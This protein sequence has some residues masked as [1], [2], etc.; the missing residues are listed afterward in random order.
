MMEGASEEHALSDESLGSGATPGPVWNKDHFDHINLK[1][2]LETDGEVE[3]LVQTL[4]HDKNEFKSRFRV[5]RDILVL[6][7]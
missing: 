5:H 6:D 7:L 1:K 2:E 3:V 4:T